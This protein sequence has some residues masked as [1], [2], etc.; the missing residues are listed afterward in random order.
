MERLANK[1]ACE[2]VMHS[3]ISDDEDTREYYVYGLQLVI[4]AILTFIAMILVAAISGHILECILFTAFFCPLRS[5]AG[6]YHCQRFSSCFILSLSLWIILVF[7]LVMNVFSHI[8]LLSILI[9]IANMY[10]LFN[11]PMEHKNNPLSSDEMKVF[12]KHVLIILFLNNICYGLCIVFKVYDY[13][14]ILCYSMVAIAFLMIKERLGG[15]K[16]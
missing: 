5:L 7:M 3:I 15:E 1:I 10:I 2:M 14:L 6:G 8:I 12:R 16:I 9:T 13:A 4:S 11:A